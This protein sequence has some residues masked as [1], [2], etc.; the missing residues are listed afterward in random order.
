MEPYIVWLILGVVL[1]VAEIF[2]P[3]FFIFWFGVGAFVASGLSVAFGTLVQVTAFAVVSGLL[4]LFTRP[5]AKK[6][7]GKEPRKI[8][9]DEIIGKTAVVTET[10]DNLA[11]KGLI[12]V[13]GDVWRALSVDDSI[14]E[15]GKKVT[16]LKVDGTH[17]VVKKIEGGEQK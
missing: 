13:G 3:S 17:L 5:F 4:V 16:I 10:I 1:V 8:H 6:I 9:I 12:R 15:S 11:G 14:V 2:I 7:S